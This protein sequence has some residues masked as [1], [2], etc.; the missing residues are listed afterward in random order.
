M[1]QRIFKK[2]IF[3]ETL[4]SDAGSGLEMDAK[5]LASSDSKYCYF[6][7]QVFCSG[8]AACNGYVVMIK[9]K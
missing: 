9:Y 2:M 3:V 1:I 7:V 8:L 4:M 5:L 6:L